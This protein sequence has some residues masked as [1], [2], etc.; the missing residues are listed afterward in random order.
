MIEICFE[1]S[2]TELLKVGWC[3]SEFSLERLAL[4]ISYVCKPTVKGRIQTKND[5]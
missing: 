3:E 1:N 2:K 4:F 5:V